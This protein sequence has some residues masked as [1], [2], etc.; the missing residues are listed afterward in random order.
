MRI[1]ICDL[2]GL[3]IVYLNKMQIYF[4]QIRENIQLVHFIISVKR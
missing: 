1:M 3:G 4:L 2:C